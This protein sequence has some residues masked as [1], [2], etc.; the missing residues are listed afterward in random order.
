MALMFQRLAR[1]FI[2]NGYFPTDSETTQRI[3]TVLAPAKAGRMRIIDPCAGEGVALAE[4]KHHLGA[5]RV[6]AFG[7]EYD[8]ERAWHAKSVL[9]RCIHGDFHDCIVGQRQFGLLWLN[10]PYGD[11]VTDKADTGDRGGKGR[12]RLEKLFYQLA[13]PK[14][15]FGGVMVLIIPRYT[16]DAELATWIARHFYRVRVYTAPE[17]QFKQVVVFGVRKRAGAA[18]VVD[19]TEAAIRKRLEAVSGEMGISELPDEWLEEHYVVPAEPPGD[20][21]FSYARMESAQLVDEIKRHRCLWEQFALKFGRMATQ[22]RRPLR[23]PSNWHLALL[24]AAGQ[25][26]GV[27]RSNDGQRT[28]LIKGDTFKEKDVKTE[29]QERADG[30]FAEVRTHTDKFV[31][32]IRALDFTPG[33][34]YGR[35]VTIR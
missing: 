24:L 2:K 31:P 28:L 8:A 10:P 13:V 5:D 25:V 3:L 33:P 20:L 18:N 14:L 23:A 17:Q 1:N 7:V 26:S 27:V 19:E 34:G 30:N 15:Q 32:V 11:L 12:K 21:V 6:E 35:V 22:H 29:L 4:C 16:L 9:D